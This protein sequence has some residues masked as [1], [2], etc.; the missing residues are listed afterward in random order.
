MLDEQ[1]L[2][3]LYRQYCMYAVNPASYETWLK[4]Y[5]KDH[6]LYTQEE[7]DDAKVRAKALHASIRVE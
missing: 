6:N 2:S 4:A 5:C 7:I 1:Q 3:H